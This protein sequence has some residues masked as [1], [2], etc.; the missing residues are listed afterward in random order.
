MQVKTV[1]MRVLEYLE[2]KKSASASELSRALKM[3]P[4][5]ARH[6]LRLLVEQG[7]VTESGQA[8][9]SGRGRPSKRYEPAHLAGRHNLHRLADVLL[10]SYLESLPPDEHPAALARLAEQ[11][12]QGFP[13]PS[14]SLTHR[15]GQAVQQLN[16]FHHDARW[17]ARPDAPRIVLGHCPYLAI[18]PGHPELCR[19]DAWLLEKA[20]GLPVIQ[21]ARLEKDA[22]GM[23][24]CVFT[25]IKK[26]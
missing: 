6:H 24:G 15:L 16:D 8:Q 19:L 2:K 10:L 12:A 21:K 20:L 1:R 14:G 17:E 3:T 5:N 4:A 11:L 26:S 13:P 23:V 22:R 7:L 18:L 25:V 9:R